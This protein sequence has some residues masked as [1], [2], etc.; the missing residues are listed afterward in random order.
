MAIVDV[1]SATTSAATSSEFACDGITAL[2]VGLYGAVDERVGASLE[3][4]GPVA[5]IPLRKEKGKTVV[6]TQANPQYPISKAGNYRIYKPATT[7]SIGAFVD[8]GS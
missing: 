6:L 3:I 8:D 5:F 1:L 4:E 2:T 7:G